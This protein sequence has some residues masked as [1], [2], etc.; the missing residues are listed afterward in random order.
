MS[1]KKIETWSQCTFIKEGVDDTRVETT[2]YIDA[3]EAKVGTRM[4]LKGIEGIWMIEKVGRPG[5]RPHW[6]WGGMD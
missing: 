5:P 6:G 2:A 3:K 1:K 4:S